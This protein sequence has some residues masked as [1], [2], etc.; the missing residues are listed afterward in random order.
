M[1]EDELKRRMYG[2]KL[3]AVPD[4]LAFPGYEDEFAP[5]SYMAVTPGQVIHV[6]FGH[7]GNSFNWTVPPGV[8]SIKVECFGGGGGSGGA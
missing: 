5:E 6:T 4:P 8:T 7:T 1:T 3:R 2:P